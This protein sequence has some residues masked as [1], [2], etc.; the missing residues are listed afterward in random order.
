MKKVDQFL[1]SLTDETLK[2]AA[3]TFFGKRKELEDEKEFLRGQAEKLKLQAE[4]IDALLSR[5][6]YVLARG[7]AAEKFWSDLGHEPLADHSLEWKNDVVVPRAWTRKGRFLALA[8][9]LYIQAAEKIKVYLRGRY[10]DDPEIK[11]KKRLTVN[12]FTLKDQI[13]RLNK[14]IQEV[15]VCNSP[16]EVMAFARRLEVEGNHKK[17]F[18]G[19]ELVYDYNQDLCLTELDPADL[20]LKEYP[21]LPTD[22]EAMR[23]VDQTLRKIYSEFKIEIDNLFDQ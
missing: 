11:G 13:S 6:N 7:K 1:D 22:K 16:D 5:L 20:G 17:K 10:V 3:D 18:T 2:E 8:S 21:E 23:R 19:S 9:K 4:S 12:L 15:N 14:S